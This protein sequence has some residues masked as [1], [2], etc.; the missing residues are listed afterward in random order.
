[1]VRLI[2]WVAAHWR[3]KDESIWEVRGERQEF[4]Y[5]RVMCWV[6]IDRAIR[7][8]SRR[9]LP[10]PL[11]RWLR[12][13]GTR[14][15]VTSTRDSGIRAPWFRPVPGA[16]HLRCRRPAHAARALRVP[17]DPRWIDTLRGIERALVSDSLIYRYRLGDGFSDGLTGQEGTFSMCSFWYVECL[18]RM[19]DLQKA[20]FFFEKMLGYANHVG[21]YGEE[22]GPARAAPRQLP[23]GLHTPGAHQRRLRSRSTALG[24]GACRLSVRQYRSVSWRLT[25]TAQAVTLLQAIGGHRVINGSHV[26]VYSAN[27]DADR[28][29]LRDVLGLPHVDAGGGWLI[30]GL[31]PS[32]VAVHPADDG[33]RHELYLMCADI[34]RF[35]TTVSERGSPAAR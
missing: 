32:E 11:P 20:R 23:A 2:D 12:R 9:S 13:P 22:L 25:E 30:F 10:A 27:P 29:F 7:L 26:I 31:P 4:L 19:G 18:S 15:T 3:E 14:S 21:L 24:G 33:D 16:I 8:A 35:R 34:E 5:S 1:M 6:A 17:T 28:A